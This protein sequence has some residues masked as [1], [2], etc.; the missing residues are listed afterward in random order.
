[1]PTTSFYWLADNVVNFI[2]HEIVYGITRKNVNKNLEI[3][4]INL[5]EQSYNSKEFEGP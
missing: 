2:R 1:M 3:T 5:Q 4:N